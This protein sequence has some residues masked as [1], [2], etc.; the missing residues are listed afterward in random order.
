MQTFSQQLNELRK[1]RHIT[2]EQLAQE[3]NVSRTTI[4]R[5]EKGIMIPDIDTIKRLS[6][7]LNYNFF[8][9]EGLQENAQTENTA[10][11]APVDTAEQEASAEQTEKKPAP[12]KPVLLAVLVIVLLCA[13]AFFFFGGQK[14]SDEPSDEPMKVYEPY[15]YEWYQQAQQPVDGQAFVRIWLEEEP[16]P[17]IKDAD[18]PNGIGWY[19]CFNIDEVNG[20]PFTVEKAVYQLYATETDVGTWTFEGEEII[21]TLGNPMIVNGKT[22]TW[23]GGMKYQGIKS[24]ALALAGTDA[25][26]NKLI[27][28]K[29]VELSHKLPD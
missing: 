11:E 5:W 25:N 28:G 13:A 7:V 20:V 18:F 8:A 29:Y 19:F 17:V 2:Q 9:V 26:G 24:A 14:P 27:F 10:V 23:W 3:M 15:T 22:A 4:S 12:K 6:Q 1:E 16:V 21:S